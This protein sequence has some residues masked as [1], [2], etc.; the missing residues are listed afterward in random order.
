MYTKKKTIPKNE[1]QKTG[2]RM[3]REFRERYE[4]N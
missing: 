2:L 4:N 3:D 1:K